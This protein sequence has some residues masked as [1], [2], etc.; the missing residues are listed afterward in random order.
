MMGM[1]ACRITLELTV[2][3]GTLNILT[4][5]I[6]AVHFGGGDSLD[7]GLLAIMSAPALAHLGTEELAQWLRFCYT[8]RRTRVKIPRIT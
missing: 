7:P 4:N 1:L 5:V 3:N 6:V 2:A 8:N